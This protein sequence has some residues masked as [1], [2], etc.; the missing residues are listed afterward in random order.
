MSEHNSKCQEAKVYHPIALKLQDR[1]I[2]I[3]G[4]GREAERKVKSLLPY[5]AKLKVISPKVTKAIAALAEE[6]KL[7]LERRRYRYGDLARAFIVIACAPGVSEEVHR[8]AQERNILFNALDRLELCD[9]ISVATFS[10]GA[11]QVAIH[12]SGQSAALSRRIKER[13][14]DE[15][16]E[17]HAK[18]VSLLNQ[19]RPTI[20]EMISTPEERRRFWLSVV[21]DKLLQRI[22]SGFSSEELK[23]EILKRA[24][25][26]YGED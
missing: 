18:L 2:V 23:K 21:N 4:G 12:T 6:G 15:I 13:L 9:F 19:L 8:E 22:K 14:E 10:R 7:I 11:L 17:E 25:G 5:K 26:F 16:G 1:Q 20:K 3:I 24:E